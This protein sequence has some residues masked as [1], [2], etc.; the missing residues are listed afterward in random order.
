[1]QRAITFDNIEKKTWSDKADYISVSD[2]LGEQR[3]CDVYIL[4]L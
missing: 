1:M 3:E 4:N 2:Y